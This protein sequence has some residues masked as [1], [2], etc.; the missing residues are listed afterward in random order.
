M[1][2]ERQLSRTESK[3]PENTGGFHDA[4]NNVAY[5]VRGC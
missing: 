4:I 3:I 5:V 2:K 1:I